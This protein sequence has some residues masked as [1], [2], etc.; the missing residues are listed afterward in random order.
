MSLDFYTIKNRKILIASICWS[1]CIWALLGSTFGTWLSV[2]NLRSDYFWDTTITCIR[3]CPDG[4]TIDAQQTCPDNSIATTNTFCGDSSVQSPNTN[5]QS[6]QCDDGNQ[7]GGDGC[8]SSCSVETY[9]VSSSARCGDGIVQYPNDSWQYE[10]CDDGNGDEWDG[11]NNQCSWWMWSY[12][13]DTTSSSDNSN[14]DNSTAGDDNSG[15]DSC[16]N[17]TAKCWAD[18]FN[19][20]ETGVS[21]VNDSDQSS[22]TCT[23]KNRNGE[24]CPS[25]SVSCGQPGPDDSACECSETGSE[26]ITDDAGNTVTDES[27]NAITR[28]IIS[29]KS[30]VDPVT[31]NTKYAG[32]SCSLRESTEN[33]AAL[34]NIRK[35]VDA[36]FGTSI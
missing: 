34:E 9:N 8:D 13:I 30:P 22:W 27:G 10:Q 6:E 2:K 5:G 25:S 24:L 33:R 17:G 36:S 26:S 31:G 23:L 7:S 29:C 32:L 28:P 11:C 35:Q 14:V 19:P 4:S 18:S 1:L 15:N 12:W 21:S 16:G 3:T 20:C